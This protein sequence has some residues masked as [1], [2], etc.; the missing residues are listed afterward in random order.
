MYLIL[1]LS[2]AKSLFSNDLLIVPLIIDN[3][4][5]NNVLINQNTKALFPEDYVVEDAFHIGI[6]VGISQWNDVIG[7]VGRDVLTSVLGSSEHITE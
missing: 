2:Q 1:S 3:F 4:R 5:T 6:P 7:K